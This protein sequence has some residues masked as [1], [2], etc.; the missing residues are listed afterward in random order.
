MS[1]AIKWHQLIIKLILSNKISNL[2]NKSQVAERSRLRGPHPMEEEEEQ[3]KV[4]SR[5]LAILIVIMRNKKIIL[6]NS[7][8]V[9]QIWTTI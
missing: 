1:A 9:R 5:F 6:H 7:N 8:K 2:N 4:T 3:G